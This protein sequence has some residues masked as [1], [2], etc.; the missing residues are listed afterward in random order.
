MALFWS[1]KSWYISSILMCKIPTCIFA[2]CLLSWPYQHCRTCYPTDNEDNDDADGNDNDDKHDE[3][4]GVVVNQVVDKDS[5]PGDVR[6]AG[7][8]YNEDFYRTERGR[9]SGI[10]NK[11]ANTNKNSNMYTKNNT[12]LRTFSEEKRREDGW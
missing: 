1:C 2:S 3:E 6:E 4:R 9:E 10:T 7:L 12:S 5:A 8:N 11:N